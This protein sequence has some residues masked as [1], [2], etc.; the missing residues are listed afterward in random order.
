MRIFDT[1]KKAQLIDYL[2]TIHIHD[3][4]IESIQND[5]EKS[6]VTIQFYNQVFNDRL[7][8]VFKNVKKQYKIKG[9]Y[10]NN[11]KTVNSL[12]VEDDYSYIRS[13]TGLSKEDIDDS[14]YL[15]L[16]FFSGDEFHIVS[17]EVIIITG[18]YFDNFK[19]HSEN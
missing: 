13:H 3:S 4:K 2:Y 17:K 8:I 1:L 12:T 9:F 18:W 19:A 10:Q 7:T 16:Q 6:S 15:I 5:R 14:L 11:E